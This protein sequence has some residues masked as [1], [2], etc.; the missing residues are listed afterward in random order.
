M[1]A[2]AI[3]KSHVRPEEDGETEWMYQIALDAVS[4]KLRIE[5]EEGW[6]GMLQRTLKKLLMRI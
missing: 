1:Y 4:R 2:R 6:H 5:R 3:R